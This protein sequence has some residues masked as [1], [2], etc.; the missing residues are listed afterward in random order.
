[1]NERRTRAGFTLLEILLVVVIIAIAAAVAIPSFARSFRGAKLRAST[2]TVLM[3]HRNAQSKAVLGQR[4]MAIL[5]D[6]RKGTLEMVEQPQAGETKDAFFGEVGGSGG[7]G[8]MGPDGHSEDSP[9]A[10]SAGPLPLLL[11]QLEEGVQILSFRGGQGNRRSLFREL[12]SQ[13]HVRG[14]PDRNRR[15]REPNGDHPGGRRDGTGEG[16]QVK[17]A[18]FR[19]QGSGGRGLQKSGMT[20]I[21]VML[22]VVILGMSLG[23]LV[24]AASRSL[25]VVRQARNYELAR[26][27]LGRVDAENPL[28][29]EDEI[30]AGQTGGGFDGGP[31]GWSWTRTL[32][33]F[34]EVDEQREGLFLLTTRVFWSQGERR[35]MEETVQYLYVPENSFGERT[36]KPQGL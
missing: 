20:L 21:E 25:A 9:A 17:G 6:Q 3:M 11:R 23:A 28:R 16:G 10:D 14:L 33:D 26:R 13:R 35:S 5:F 30:V 27:M 18:G 22:A 7:G 2:R 4:Y 36:L 15:R 1:M 29:L 31:A 12:L 34:G 24:E 8:T 32:E 19:V